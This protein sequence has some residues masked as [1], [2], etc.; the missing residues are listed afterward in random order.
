V[1]HDRYG[2]S[3][4]A[5]VNADEKC[6]CELMEALPV[7]LPCLPRPLPSCG[8]RGGV[9]ATDAGAPRD[10]DPARDQHKTR[11]DA[12]GGE[13]T[14]S[15]SKGITGAKVS[16]ATRLQKVWPRCPTSR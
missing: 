1:H 2:C 9:P 7:W 11:R 8:T 15:S 10:R 12:A 5:L 14:T 6:M 4:W 3:C 13:G 16:L